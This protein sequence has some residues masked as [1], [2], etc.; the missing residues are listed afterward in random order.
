MF[1]WSVKLNRNLIWSICAAV[2]LSIGAVAV[3]TPKDS[4]DVLKNSV[5]T[6]ATTTDQQVA[7][8]GAFGYEAD[9][10]PVLVEEVIIP[11]EFDD[12]YETYN[13][14]QK[15]SGFDLE[16][17]KGC[18][19]KKY[20]YTIANYSDYEDEVVANV[21]VY[22]SNVIGGDVSSVELGGFTHGFIKE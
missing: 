20:T 19:A 1:I 17:Y 22:D 4:D 14:Y 10:Q 5:N 12:A 8:L 3:F 11:T 21:L 18:R 15:L 9:A 16:D 7:F 6:A 2:C 13:G